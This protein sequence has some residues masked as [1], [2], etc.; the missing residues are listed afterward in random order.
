MDVKNYLKLEKEQL[1]K[2]RWNNSSKPPHSQKEF[3]FPPMRVEKLPK[4]WCIR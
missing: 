1:D 4:T 2:R 3:V